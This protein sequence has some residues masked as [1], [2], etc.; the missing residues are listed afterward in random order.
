MRFLR[1]DTN[2]LYIFF[3]E[4]LFCKLLLFTLVNKLLYD[5]F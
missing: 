3:S 2:K 1:F 4:N 5:Y